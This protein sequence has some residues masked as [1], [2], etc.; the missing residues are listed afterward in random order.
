M[1]RYSSVLTLCL[2]GAFQLKVEVVVFSQ[3]SLPELISPVISAG[4][5]C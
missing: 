3:F 2:C 5:K 4:L 1:G